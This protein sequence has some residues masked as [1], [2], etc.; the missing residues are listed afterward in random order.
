MNCWQAPKSEA[1][2]TSTTVLLYERYVCVGRE[3]LEAETAPC[4]CG[5][6]VLELIYSIAD[7]GSLDHLRSAGRFVLQTHSVLLSQSSSTRS[8]SAISLLLICYKASSLSL[9]VY[10]NF[11]FGQSILSCLLSTFPMTIPYF[12]YSSGF[13]LFFFCSTGHTAYRACFRFARPFFSA[14]ARLMRRLAFG[15]R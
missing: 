12:Y 4:G 11:P 6:H 7:H 14:K 8:F 3:L 10:P 9:L 15:A 5:L 13:F 1:M 2:E